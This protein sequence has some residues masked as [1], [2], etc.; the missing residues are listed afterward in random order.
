M[1]SGR[2]VK[3]LLPILLVSCLANDPGYAANPPSVAGL[4]VRLLVKPVESLL[5]NQDPRG[6][7]AP[8]FAARRA[9]SAILAE[10]DQMVIYPLAWLYSTKYPGNPY[11]GDKRVLEAVKRCGNYLAAFEPASFWPMSHWAV[12]AWMAAYQQVEQELTAEQQRS[13]KAGFTRWCTIYAGYLE[14][15]E[16]KPHLTAVEIGSSPNHYGYY[17]AAVYLAGKILDKPEWCGLALR[18]FHAL[19][20]TQNPDGYWAEHA[21]PVVRYSWLTMDGVGLYY[22]WTGDREAL[23]ALRR[24]KDFLLAFTYPDGSPVAVIDERN[25]Y[26]SGFTPVR[27]LMAL[28][29]FPDGRRFCRVMTEAYLARIESGELKRLDPVALSRYVDA[30][31][32]SEPGEETAI[33]QEMKSFDFRLASGAY[34][35]RRGPWTITLSGIISRPWEGNRFFLDRYTYLEIWHSGT[36]LV[37]G[38]GN[39]KRQPQI[40]TLL[41]EPSNSGVDY[42][43]LSSRITA[44]GDSA[45]L[46]LGFETFRGAL[47]VRILD[48]RKAAF[49]ASYTELAEPQLWPN[50]YECNLQLQLKTGWK[51]AAGREAASYTLSEQRM[52]VAENALGGSLET[53][54]WR[55]SVPEGKTSL[56]FPFLPF[57]NY[58][59]DGHGGL[60]GAVGILSSAERIDQ[61]PLEYLLEIK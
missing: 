4:Y 34:L 24:T 50:R 13:W 18:A 14:K 41:M 37:I 57:F 31:K 42:Q 58:D 46:E 51:I 3:F 9:G 6:V 27:G 52:Q 17:S 59:V 32:Y 53:D 45:T 12:Y 5:E 28:S 43:P 16:G 15:T 29:H 56:R 25:R 40:S 33:P 1:N 8:P 10:N 44:A 39:T 26:D 47:K 35:M 61:G 60:S 11:F 55:L 49:S 54:K 30:I 48:E 38:G 22:A 20:R 7:F 19:V 36:G 23:E 2:L 21:G